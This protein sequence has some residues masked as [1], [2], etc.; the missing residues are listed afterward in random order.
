MLPRPLRALAAVVL[1]LGMT[2]VARAQADRFRREYPVQALA[3]TD[4]DAELGIE[5]NYFGETIRRAGGGRLRYSNHFLQEYYQGRARGYA[6]HPRFLTYSAQVRLG[7][8]QQWLRRDS[9]GD[10]SSSF[11]NDELLGYDL[12][13]DFFKDHP[14]SASVF[15][16]RDERILMGLFVDRYLVRTEAHGGTL[17]WKN[18]IAPMNLS[19]TRSKVEEFGFNSRSTT[20]TDTLEYNLRHDIGRRSRTDVQARVQSIDRDFE[21]DTFRGRVERET[22]LD[23]RTIQATN[24]LNLDAQG[25]STLRSTLRYH[26]Q[27]NA[28]D[29]T[30][31]YWQ[32]RLQLQHSRNLR[33]YAEASFLRNDYS[34][35]RRNDTYRAEIGVD[36]QLYESLRTHFDIHGRRTVAQV[37]EEDRYGATAQLQYRKK[38]GLGVFSAGFSKTLDQVE[39]T[40][41]AASDDILDEALTLFIAVPT[42]LSRGDVIAPSIVV[43][44]VTNTII[45]TEGF[46][47]ELV[48]Q[49][50]RTGLRVVPGGLLADGDQVLVDYRIEVDGDASY[51]ADDQTIY[52]RHDFERGIKGLSLYAQRH[53]LRARRIDAADDFGIVEFTD[54]MVGLRQEWRQ[55]AFVSEYQEFDDD[56]GGFTQWRNRLEGTHRL[57]SRTRLGWN[58]GINKTD[59]SSDRDISGQDESD[60]RFAGVFVD[61]RFSNRGF[62]RVEGRTMRETGRTES[63]TNGLLARAGFEWRRM[64]IEGGARFEQY[65]VFDTERDRVHVFVRMRRS[66]GRRPME[67]RR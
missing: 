29:L 58:V 47:Y 51:I 27:R 55:F 40:G 11:D 63:T 43:T 14:L 59:Y 18:D 54:Q 10:R 42:F 61:G 24:R 23:T 49:G 4:T 20:L 37:T 32:E 25:R 13:L 39:R 15:A 12:R 8:S 41:G 1:L 50:R 21:A 28:Q 35:G 26:Q 9:D 60:Y 30:T 5:Y 7:L 17:R 62:W 52:L 57:D 19:V 46:D 44:D 34:D 3:V 36:H 16:R 48:R 33:S 22:E 67:G 66:L 45:Y 2:S 65:E 53:D 56:L 64:T 31:L 38:T 6:Y